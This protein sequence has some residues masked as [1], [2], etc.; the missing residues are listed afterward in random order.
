MRTVADRIA[1]LEGSRWAIGVAF[2]LCAALDISHQDYEN[3]LDGEDGPARIERA[4][5]I[6]EG[7]SVVNG[8]KEA[9]NQALH[10]AL[11]E[12]GSELEESDT[13]EEEEDEDTDADDTEGEED[14]EMAEDEAG[15]EV[16]APL[17]A[18]GRPASQPALLYSTGPIRRGKNDTWLMPTV[19]RQYKKE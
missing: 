14:M 1:A 7:W 12:A 3:V 4:S 19:L 11:W 15:D 9:L 2:R 17:A 6:L 8:T 5:A 16:E 13:E 10:D 18:M